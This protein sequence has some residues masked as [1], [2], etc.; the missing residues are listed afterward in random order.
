MP[1]RVALSDIQLIDRLKLDDETALTAVYKKYWAP[2]YI[3]AYQVLKNKE[4][5][6]DIIQE[7]FIKLWNNRRSI[8]IMVSLKA[9]L[10]AAIRYEVYRQIRTGPVRADIF[11]EVSERIHTPSVY[12]NIEYKELTARV[13]S[14]VDTLPEKCRE[15]YKLSREECLSHKEI[16][17]QLNIS[18]KTVEN[19]LTRALRQLRT[20]IGSSFLL[21]IICFF[22]IN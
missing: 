4:A 6:E 3:A 14:V 19:H 7:L 22:I 8:M 2:L 20:F 18:T 13:S 21:Y 9:Y 10:Y 15:V 11:D 12:N 16:A 17:S 5:C 1:E